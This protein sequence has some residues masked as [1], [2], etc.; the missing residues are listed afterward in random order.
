MNLQQFQ[1][2]LRNAAEA[3]RDEAPN[4]VRRAG[5]DALAVVE[6]RIKEKGIEGERYK[7]KGKAAYFQGGKGTGAFKNYAT[8]GK[9]DLTLTN[10]MWNGT[11]VLGVVQLRE[12]VFQAQIGGTDAEVDAKIIANVKRFGNFLEPNEQETAEIQ[13][14]MQAEVLDV[15]RRYID[16]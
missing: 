13:E 4:I 15:I 14:D 16:R 10:R 11:A 2:S 3:V 12:N 5:M 8:H 1:Q 7:S 6:R 9:V